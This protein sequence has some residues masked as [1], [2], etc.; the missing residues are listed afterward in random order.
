MVKEIEY[1]INKKDIMKKIEKNY[2]K[3]K[4]IDI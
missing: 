3:K 4:M 1:Q 2:N